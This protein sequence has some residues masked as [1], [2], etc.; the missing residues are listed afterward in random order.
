MLCFSFVEFFRLA[1]PGVSFVV[2]WC[3]VESKK[4]LKCSQVKQQFNIP[5]SSL[6]KL[7]NVL[8]FTDDE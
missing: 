2:L 8:H 4:P 3:F 5:P 1:H 7:Y 6:F